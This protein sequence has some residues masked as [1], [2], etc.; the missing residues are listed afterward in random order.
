MAG[1]AWCQCMRQLLSFEVAVPCNSATAAPA[2]APTLC[3]WCHSSGS[4]GSTPPAYP[5]LRTKLCLLVTVSSLSKCLPSSLP[6]EHQMEQHDIKV[7]SASQA[8]NRHLPHAWLVFESLPSPGKDRPEDAISPEQPDV[9]LCPPQWRCWGC[10]LPV[11]P[12]LRGP[13][14]SCPDQRLVPPPGQPAPSAAVPA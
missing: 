8:W 3:I 4:A 9:K 11:Y 14:P 10:A 12:V 1:P 2:A 6:C 7:V 5:E 13:S